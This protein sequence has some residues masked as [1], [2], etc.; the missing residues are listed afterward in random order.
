MF[1]KL[2]EVCNAFQCLRLYAN[3]R[4]ISDEARVCV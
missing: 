3:A 2:E 4:D 1:D